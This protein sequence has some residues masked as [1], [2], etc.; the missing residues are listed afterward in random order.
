[1]A[2]GL[3][4]APTFDAL[5]ALVIETPQLRFTLT[6]SLATLHVRLGAGHTRVISGMRSRRLDILPILKLSLPLLLLG[7]KLLDFLA[8]ARARRW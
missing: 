4:G 3:L 1:M 5:L 6:L 8:L 7:L 2:P